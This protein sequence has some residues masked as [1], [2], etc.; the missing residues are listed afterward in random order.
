MNMQL[1]FVCSS[2]STTFI[3]SNK[4]SSFTDYS[5]TH[6]EFVWKVIWQPEFVHGW[7]KL[8]RK[9]WQLRWRSWLL[10]LWHGELIIKRIHFLPIHF[11]FI[12]QSFY[13]FAGIYIRFYSDWS[14]VLF[15]LHSFSCIDH[16]CVRH[17]QP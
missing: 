9:S 11:Y 16:S 6:Q 10:F 7:C 15:I 4:F 3:E 17:P 8:F 1:N 12:I 13:F 2:V 14:T 5:I